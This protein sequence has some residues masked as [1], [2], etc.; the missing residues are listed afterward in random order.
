MAKAE[1]SNTP[2]SYWVSIPIPEFIAW[3]KD[4]NEA[5]KEDERRRPKQK[6]I[7]RTRR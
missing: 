4:I 3:I 1:V 5:A 7:P 2:V 6:S